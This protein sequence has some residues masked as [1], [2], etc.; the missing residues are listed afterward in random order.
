MRRL[1]EEWPLNAAD[2]E[3][4]EP[5]YETFSG[6]ATDISGARSM[7]ELPGEARQYVA[8]IEQR[9]GVP[10]S[11]ISVGPERNQT[12]V[13]DESLLAVAERAL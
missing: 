9:A 5:V 10:I 3:R 7:A 1:I 13:V 11:H 8:A 4:A 6:W 2:L 12:I